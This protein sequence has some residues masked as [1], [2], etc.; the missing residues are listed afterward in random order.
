MEIKLVALGNV[1]MRDD[2]IAIALAKEMEQELNKHNI[3]VIYGE[4]DVAYCI[5]MIKDTDY[6]IILDASYLGKLPGAITKIP[7]YDDQAYHLLGSQHSF[8]ILDLLK[9][10]V[11]RPVGF[12]LAVEIS[13][14]YPCNQLSPLLK[15]KV[16]VIAKEVLKLI[17]KLTIESLQTTEMMP[18]QTRNFTREE[19]AAYD[20]S[21]GKPAYVA[22]NDT[23]Y[24]VSDKIQWAGGS[25]FGLVAGKD[26]T[27]DFMGC[28]Q[29]LD[30]ILNTLPKVGVLIH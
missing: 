14:I 12:I 22:I 20:G 29:G 11:P 23:V 1:L 25:H 28:H 24:D 6:L 17:E 19:L 5:S 4:T 30:L 21:G 18:D 9:L 10:Y 8:S 27:A 13:E 26:L 7:F 2:G 15:G 16:K 3:E